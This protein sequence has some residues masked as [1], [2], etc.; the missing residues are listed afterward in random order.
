MSFLAGHLLLYMDPFPAF[1]CFA[2]I[3]NTPFMLAFAKV[4]SEKMNDRYFLFNSLL[5]STLPNI[6]NLFR[7][8][9]IIPDMYLME[10]CCTLFCMFN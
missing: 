3:L 4:D 5:E 2:N 8:E 1:V 6:S 9:N 10:L 7:N